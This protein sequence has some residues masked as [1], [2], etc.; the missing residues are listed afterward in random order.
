MRDLA[1]DFRYTLRGLRQAPVFT[2]AA[3]LSMAFGIGAN[4]A[5]F[6]LVD[7]VL[8]RRL[9]VA[10]PAE[11]V[12]VH[13]Q[14]TESYGGGMGDGTELSY[15]MY[16]DLREHNQAF[17]EMFCRFTWSFQV[18]YDGRAERADGEMVSGSFFPALGVGAAVGRV[19]G[20]GDDEKP[21]GHPVVVLSHRY[22]KARF[23]GDPSVVGKTMVLN[24][25]PFEVIGVAEERFNGLDLGAPAQLYV[26]MAMQPQM[27]PE[28]LK[29]DTHRF[30]WVQVFGR[31][32]P[33]LTA[34]KAQA[35]LQPLYASLLEAEAADAEAFKKASEDTRKV[36]L[37]GK[38]KVESA[39]TGH[40]DLRQQVTKP[41]LVLMAVAAAV[42]LLVCANVAALLVARGLAR[43][44]ELAVRLAIG[45]TRARL[46]RLLMVESLAVAVL[47][48]AVGLML[49]QAGAGVLLAYFVT[50]ENPLAV[51]AEADGRVLL[52]TALL[53]ASAALGAGLVASLRAAS[54]DLAP[55]LKSTSGS[56]AAP[57]RLQKGLIVAQVSLSF[58]L[59]IGAGLFV[60][61]VGNL[62]AV[63]PGF[64]TDHVVTFGVDIE[65]SGYKGD[66][67]RA[68][69]AQLLE[70]MA[71]TPGVTK[72]AG[73]FQPLLAGGGWGMGFTI[74]GFTPPKGDGAGSLCNAVSP[75]F[76]A[77]MGIPVLEGREFDARD[78]RPAGQPD[79]DGWPY[80]VAVVNER[81]A[82]KYFEGKSPLGRHVGI[83]E[84]PGTA[85]PIEIVG[86]V[87]DTKY[88]AIKEDR[89]PQIFF[90]FLQTGIDAAVFYA[91]TDQP[92]DAAV[93]ALRRSVSSVDP[94]LALYGVGTLDGQVQRSIV[95][96]RAVASLSA[97][98]SGI[99]TL[100]AVIGLYGVLGYSVARRTREIG[101]R[102]ALGARERQ[103]A[104]AVL[105]EAGRL[106]AGGLLIGLAFAW[107]LG[108]Y[109]ESQLF[110]VSPGDPRSFAVAAALLAS[111]AL[112]AASFPAR[113]A[114]KVAP[115][116]ALR[117]D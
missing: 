115:M 76:F 8:L 93:A 35:A 59:L 29:L 87:K 43:R 17:S 22:W 105:G 88:M 95:N 74:E 25:H 65:R 33:G 69:F 60:R 108:R 85:M 52:F 112:A 62:L 70:A 11:L 5:V 98:L 36:F 53:G 44:R 81:F 117:Q 24:G 16:R 73:V 80:R 9:P 84:D 2:I 68:L 107:W 48:S 21:G 102:I 14:G 106:V 10:K 89:R 47:G 72:S 75:G 12:Q 39:A 38:L 4:T 103:I 50:P 110:G 58:L 7:Q 23:G 77:T 100:L 6:T 82:E 18:G 3:V 19:L 111:V 83:G 96:E 63:D 26:P 46:V 109:L 28:W 64:K 37:A 78:A 113:R 91:R 40:S 66:R 86:L 42:M 15:A 99:A 101:I 49:A 57:P 41:L 1:A 56:V 34:Q 32:K 67:G 54:G 114:A 90:P 92:V 31:M 51:S 27:G 94:N 20:E 30:R 104:Q 116:T 55:T 61:T 45:A 13:A 79:P 71:T 97:A